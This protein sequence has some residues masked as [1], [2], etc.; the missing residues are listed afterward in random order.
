METAMSMGVGAKIK[1]D[2][3]CIN[4]QTDRINIQTLEGEISFDKSIFNK[5]TLMQINRVVINGVAFVREAAYDYK[6]D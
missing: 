4:I 6:T 2:E 3:T 1:P 5:E